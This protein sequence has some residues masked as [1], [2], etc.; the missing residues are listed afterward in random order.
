M[1]STPMKRKHQIIE[2]PHH[3]RDA[4]E[5]Y[6]TKAFEQNDLPGLAV[7]LRIG[8]AAD[9]DFTGVRGL[10]DRTTQ[11]PLN[12]DAVFHM[13]SVAKLFVATAV[14]QLAEADQLD[15]DGRLIDY[16]PEFQMAD[17][18]VQDIRLRHLLSHTAGMPDIQDYHWTSPETD[19]GALSRYAHSEELRGLR[20][21]W[22]PGEGRFQY[23][24]IGYDIL[25][26]VIEAVS[27]ESFEAF[28]T[29]HIFSP[30][31]M[32]NSTFL[33]FLRTPE[34]RRAAEGG[35][36][37]AGTMPAIADLKQ[38]KQNGT[39]SHPT[40][41]ASLDV[42][43]LQASGLVMPHQKD[44]QRNILRQDYYPYNRAHGPSST[45]T[46]TIEDIKKW[47]A[48]HLSGPVAEKPLLA[49]AS[50]AQCWKPTAEVPVSGEHIGLGWFIRRQND[51]I[52]YGHEGADDGF[53]AS[54]W[55]CPALQTQIIVLSNLDRA[56]VKKIGKG[57][58][59]LLTGSG[60]P[61]QLNR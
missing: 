15:I 59:D 30:L 32:S 39:T 42:N 4:L 6:L 60:S 51:E 37:S 25:G 10:A 61:Y 33:T 18:R 28:L 34:G 57:L 8:N 16:L 17:T 31:G 40:I 11:T 12:Q 1:M 41:P 27:G 36:G 2:S 43:R 49:P 47:G 48:A 53:R 5:L 50:Y 58:F 52:L 38:E 3:L 20:L 26:A 56:P 45:L 9:F 35:N 22:N 7:G 29:H 54:F 19:A 55:I 14:L 13:A 46:S 23:S 21:L 24:N 44:Q